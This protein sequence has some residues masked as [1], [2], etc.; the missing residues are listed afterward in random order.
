M[1]LKFCR[2]SFDAF[3]GKNRHTI[4]S[5]FTLR[6]H[7]S[8]TSSPIGAIVVSGERTTYSPNFVRPPL[9]ADPMALQPVDRE[10]DMAKIIT[11]L[12]VCN[13]FTITEL[14]PPRTFFFTGAPRRLRAL[15]EG[16]W[17]GE[18]SR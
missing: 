12:H 13:I 17:K 15:C 1:I 11:S 8:T 7:S 6:P 10:Q 3:C 5:G 18:V 2:C 9:S 16:A 4:R 14:R